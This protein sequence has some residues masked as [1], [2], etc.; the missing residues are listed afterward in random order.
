[1]PSAKFILNKMITG[2]C[3]PIDTIMR[4]LSKETV[5]AIDRTGQVA[6]ILFGMMVGF[7]CGALLTHPVSLVLAVTVLFDQS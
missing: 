6:R 7:C 2:M 3:L 5:P 1:M 4:E